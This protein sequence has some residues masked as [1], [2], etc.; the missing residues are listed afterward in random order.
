VSLYPGI[1]VAA[2]GFDTTEGTKMSKGFAR[3]SV[4]Q[5]L[6]AVQ[7]LLPSLHQFVISFQQL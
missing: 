2:I 3:L 1:I 6:A 5:C 4:M 7:Q